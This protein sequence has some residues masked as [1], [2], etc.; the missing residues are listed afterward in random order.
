MSQQALFSIDIWMSDLI[1]YAMICIEVQTR[2][3]TGDGWVAR[4]GLRERWSP[5]LVVAAASAGLRACARRLPILES[6]PCNFQ[7]PKPRLGAIEFP[8]EWSCNR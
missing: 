3:D 5:R 2:L 1:R 8:S 4:Q 7:P 6:W